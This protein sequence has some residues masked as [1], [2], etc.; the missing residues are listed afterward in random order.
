LEFVT[1]RLTYLYVFL[2]TA[3]VFLVLGYFLGRRIEEL[4]RLS[5]TDSLTGL[6]NQRAF[7]ARLQ[8]EWHRAGRYQSP[9]SLLFIDIDGLKR[10]NDE[11][12]HATGDVVLRTAAHAINATMRTSDFGARWGGDE[13][14][15]VAPNTPRSAA[16]Q[17]AQRLLG[18]VSEQAR[19][20]GTPVTL[21]VGVATWEP[22]QDSSASIERLRG[23]ADM[24]LYRAKSDGRNCV[25][26]A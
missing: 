8:E 11:R 7:Q 24:A 22:E 25:R 17:L 2:A 16:Q 10:I 1:N 9:L 12:G 6:A 19:A 18:H 15:I 21:S 23:A 13:F 3:T 4:R 14:G 20:R 5:T 26:V